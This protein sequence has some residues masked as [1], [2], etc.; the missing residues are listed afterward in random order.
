MAI[1]TAEKTE[2][3]FIVLLLWVLRAE[4]SWKSLFVAGRIYQKAPLIT[5][6]LNGEAYDCTENILI[7]IA[8]LSCVP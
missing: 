6:L 3:E 5:C 1:R 7:L 4:K 8:K 2:P